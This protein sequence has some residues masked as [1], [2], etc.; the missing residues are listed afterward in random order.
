MLGTV[1]R[2]VE[3]AQGSKAP[4]QKLADKIASVFVPVVILISIATFLIWL[5]LGGQ[6][7]AEFALINAVAVLIIACPC[8]LGL[9]TP[10]AVMVG[11]GLGAASGILIKNGESL[12]VAHK[13]N[14]IVFD[15]TGTI[16]EGKPT[17]VEVIPVGH[18]VN[19]L[20]SLIAALE[21]KSE[22]PIARAIVNY[23]KNKNIN[24]PDAVNFISLT[25]FGIKGNVNS[26]KITAGN[27]K[28]MEAEN[29]DTS[30]FANENSSS[31]EK[32]RTT[33]W[34]ASENKIIGLIII[35]DPIR[36]SSRQSVEKLKTMGI[37]VFMF[38][39]DNCPNSRIS[40][41]FG[42]HGDF[43]GEDAPEID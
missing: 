17:V 6:N 24:I 38:S 10:T 21:I 40:G 19:E 11:T 22:H 25:G 12:E 41:G 8:A 20:I 2:M 23:A 31:N 28:L 1:I 29:I 37:N 34:A 39:G 5:L 27:L 32:G 33:V 9:A 14:T 43:A 3:E 13:V 18:S 35:E 30:A 42:G 15:K 26:R 36:I 4:I 16:T 7:S